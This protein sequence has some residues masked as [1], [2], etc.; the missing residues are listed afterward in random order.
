VEQVSGRELHLFLESKQDFST[1]IKARIE[2]YGFIENQDFERFH[3]F[4]EACGRLI[5]YALSLD[6]AKEI[7]NAT[8]NCIIKL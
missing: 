7:K 6:C 4:M 8:R 5:E 1:W 2:K 3:N